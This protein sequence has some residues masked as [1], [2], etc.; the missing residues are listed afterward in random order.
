MRSWLNSILERTI[1]AALLIGYILFQLIS[2]FVSS[3][4][5]MILCELTFLG[6]LIAGILWLLEDYRNHVKFKSL[7]KVIGAVF[8]ANMILTLIYIPLLVLNPAVNWTLKGETEYDPIIL[9]AL[10]P[11]VHLIVGIIILFIGVLLI[12]LFSKK[13]IIA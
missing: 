11:A 1:F 13:K 4:F 10:F 3:G 6:S 2:L 7:G 9:M 5:F 8:L 12:K